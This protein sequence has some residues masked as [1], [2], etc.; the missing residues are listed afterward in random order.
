VCEGAGTCGS[1]WLEPPE[2][3]DERW[4]TF[5]CRTDTR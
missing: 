1:L 3:W 2:H 4:C 5:C